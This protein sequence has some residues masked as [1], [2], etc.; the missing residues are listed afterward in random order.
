MSSCFPVNILKL[1]RLFIHI[2]IFRRVPTFAEGA[3]YL[4]HFLPP[5]RQSDCVRPFVCPTTPNGR[6]YVKFD[7]GDFYKNMLNSKR[8]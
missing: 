7:I 3:N 8:G 4:R 2:R 5:V 6:A 1:K